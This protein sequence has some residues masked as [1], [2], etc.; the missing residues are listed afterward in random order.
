MHTVHV[1]SNFL[2]FVGSVEQKTLNGLVNIWRP[3]QKNSALTL[4]FSM[5]LE[6]RTCQMRK[7]CSFLNHN[8]A[9]RNVAKKQANSLLNRF[10]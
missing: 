7:K 2:I 9:T 3:K 4:Q 5:Y 6:I 1:K 8:K 10:I